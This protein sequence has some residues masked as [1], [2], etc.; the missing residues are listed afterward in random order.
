MDSASI[1]SKVIC[2]NLSDGSSDDLYSCCRMKFA[3]DPVQTQALHLMNMGLLKINTLNESD[4][5]GTPATR[6]QRPTYVSHWSALDHVF[7][8]PTAVEMSAAKSDHDY[9]FFFLFFRSG[10]RG[11]KAYSLLGG[12]IPSQ[13]IG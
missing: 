12:V 13:S 8:K 6:T 2:H 1:F 3:N 4:V 10:H 11:P 7:G 5:F 9:N